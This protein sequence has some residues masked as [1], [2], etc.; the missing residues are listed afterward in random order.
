MT[1]EHQVAAHY[2]R[3]NLGQQL[4]A[5][6]TEAGDAADEFHLRG[7]DATADL[8][9]ALMLAVGQA[10][11]DVGS[12]TGGPSRHLARRH[13]CAITGIDLSEDYCAA[14]TLLAK[15]AGLSDRLTY[16][17]GS[18]LAM[19]FADG[20]FDRAYSEHVAMNIDDKPALYHEIARVLQPGA[21]F[22][23]YDLL[24]GAGGPVHYPAPWA[25]TAATSF[26]VTPEA[27]RGLLADAGFLVVSW[28]DRTTECTAWMEGL[29]RQRASG[30]AAPTGLQ[31]VMGPDFAEMGR[32][33]A[34]NLAE[35]RIIP[36]EVICRRG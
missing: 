20:A 4:L 1:L 10:V 29:R 36:T 16:V 34:R 7:H 3:D 17:Q 13:G 12:G 31:I 24:Q 27:L 25:K 33:Q 21:L 23:L 6:L 8:G 35:G 19:P 22:G 15:H 9:N 11:L 14:A 32:N 26:L 2:R 28:R 18:A 30:P 5:I